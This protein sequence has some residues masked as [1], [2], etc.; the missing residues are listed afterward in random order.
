MFRVFRKIPRK[1]NYGWKSALK[2]FTALIVGIFE[3]TC[4]FDNVFLMALTSTEQQ[5]IERPLYRRFLHNDHLPFSSNLCKKISLQCYRLY[6][7]PSFR[8]SHWHCF[9]RKGALRN[10]VKFTGKHK[11]QSLFFNKLQAETTTSDHSCVF[12]LSQHKKWNEKREIP[13]WNS[14]ITLLLAYKYVWFE[15]KF[16]RWWIDQKMCLKGIWCCTFHGQRNFGNFS[17]WWTLDEL[18]F[19]NSLNFFKT[20]SK[21]WEAKFIFCNFF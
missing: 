9:I 12:I 19:V 21:F 18:Q 2:T 11:W 14:N 13:W 1:W 5:F 15:K 3:R 17:G 16:G 6:N 20:P 7:F 4:C 8:S 10:F